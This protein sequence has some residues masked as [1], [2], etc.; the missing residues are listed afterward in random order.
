MADYRYTRGGYDMLA[1]RG[2]AT[3]GATP[4]EAEPGSAFRVVA[5]GAKPV[6]RGAEWVVKAPKG[7]IAMTPEE[8]EATGWLLARPDVTAAELAAKAPGVEAA[9]LLARL[10]EAGLLVPAA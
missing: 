10:Q 4:A 5:G 9:A 7:I 3:E 6:R 2:L 8:A 1:A